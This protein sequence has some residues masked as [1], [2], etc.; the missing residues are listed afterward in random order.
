MTGLVD[1][2]LSSQHNLSTTTKLD[3]IDRQKLCLDSMGTFDAVCHQR[4]C[5]VVSVNKTVCFLA[6]AFNKG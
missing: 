1:L 5:G 6:M 2:D 3:K 4:H